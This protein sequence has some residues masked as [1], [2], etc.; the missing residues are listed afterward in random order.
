MTV[1][2][3]HVRASVRHIACAIIVAAH[4][5]LDGALGG[6]HHY[7]ELSEGPVPPVDFFALVETEAQFKW[8]GV[9]P[10][11][12]MQTADGGYVAVGSYT[13]NNN[14][15]D[16]DGEQRIAFVLK[17]DAQ[18]ETLWKH[19]FG[20]DYGDQ[21]FAQANAVTEA[22]LSQKHYLIVA[23]I[24]WDPAE[25]AYTRTLVKL[26]AAGDRVW[27][28]SFPS[29][30]TSLWSGFEYM[31]MAQD[32]SIIASGFV[33]GPATMELKFKSHGH[34]SPCQ[35]SVMKVS[36]QVLHRM[37]GTAPGLPN[38]AWERTLPVNKGRSGTSVR[39]LRTGAVL[40]ARAE[41]AGEPGMTV[42]TVHKLNGNG[43]AVWSKAIPEIMEAT[44]IAVSPRADYFILT[45]LSTDIQGGVD[46]QLVRVDA[47][48]GNVMWSKSFHS[49]PE[50]LVN[51]E[52]W[53][54]QIIADSLGEGAVVSCATGFDETHCYEEQFLPL[55]NPEKEL[56]DTKEVP[57]FKNLNMRIKAD[58]GDLVWRRVDRYQE[59]EDNGRHAD[60][61]QMF[62][63][64]MFIAPTQDGGTISFVD[65]DLG[66]GFLKLGAG[67]TGG[68]KSWN[69]A[70]KSKTAHTGEF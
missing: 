48:Q 66:V 31:S 4:V 45:G 29:P 37:G 63:V 57:Q 52:C 6:H 56:C 38:I 62:S 34:P 49:S 10:V 2:D 69:A 51:D 50:R 8:K 67:Q 25:A 21:R 33:N 42:A 23:G 13:T 43:N 39:T 55:S 35:A 54:I 17:V 27:L 26:T 36:A 47:T 41:I 64:S 12:G 5:L 20:G 68:P 15:N 28:A 7:K 1:L 19:E 11:H 3:A 59:L 16:H 61:E 14:T 24:A 58:T 65:N 22:G 32:G 53:S 70:V 9:L 30:K 18:G 44:D 46:A 60:P 40:L